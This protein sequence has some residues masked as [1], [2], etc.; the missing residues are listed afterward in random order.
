[1]D[2]VLDIITGQL[3]GTVLNE[4][5]DMQGLNPSI[6]NLARIVS[7]RLSSALESETLAAISAK[8]WEDEQAWAE[9]RLLLGN[10]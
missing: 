9:Y 5:P 2:Q 1:M 10:S 8:L 4:I 7:Q 3:Q 6:E